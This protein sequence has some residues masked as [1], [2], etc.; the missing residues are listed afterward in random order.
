MSGTLSLEHFDARRVWCRYSGQLWGTTDA[1]KARAIRDARRFYNAYPHVWIG[2]VR[3]ID[4]AGRIVWSIAAAP[5]FRLEM[6]GGDGKGFRPMTGR[7]SR[8]LSR[9][10]AERGRDHNAA[11]HG[12]PV[13]IVQEEYPRESAPVDLIQRPTF[14]SPEIQTAYPHVGRSASSL[15]FQYGERSTA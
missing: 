10:E 15:I 4:M 9:D 11:I 14:S 13:R 5:T 7:E 12:G 1:E 8:A 2:G 3:L 6:D